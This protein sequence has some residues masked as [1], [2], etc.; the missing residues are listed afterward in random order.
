MLKKR[1]RAATDRSLAGGG[2]VAA[3]LD[4]SLSLEVAHQ[5]LW[6]G[7]SVQHDLLLFVGLNPLQLVNRLVG[8]QARL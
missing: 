5:P 1:A 3:G 6:I 7:G 8:L 2:D 4:G